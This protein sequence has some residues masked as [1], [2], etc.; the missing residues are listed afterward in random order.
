MIKIDIAKC[1]GCRMCETSCSFYHSAQTSRMKSR[2][3]V[4]NIYETGVDG[5]V[6]CQQCTERYCMECSVNAMSIGKNG[7]IIISHTV[8]IQ[9]NKCMNACPIGAIEHYEEI[10]HV[11]DLCGGSPKCVE[12]CSEQAIMYAES[13]SESVS[14]KDFKIETKGKN[15]SERQANFIMQSGIGLRKKWRKEN[16]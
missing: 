6:V 14:L 5:P 11:C 13:E 8:C 10:Y 4:I 2:I 16:A 7:Q 3:K 15:V 12:D 1:T 9:C